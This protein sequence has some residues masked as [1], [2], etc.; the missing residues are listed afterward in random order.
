MYS[1]TIVHVENQQVVSKEYACNRD[2]GT[3]PVD[4]S[5]WDDLSVFDV[6]HSLKVA[7]FIAVYTINKELISSYGTNDNDF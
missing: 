1:L 3:G 4:Q 7:T 6:Q 5:F 2:N